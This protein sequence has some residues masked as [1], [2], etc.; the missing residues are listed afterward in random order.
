VL[1]EDLKDFL[2][3]FILEISTDHECGSFFADG[4]FAVDSESMTDYDHELVDY[5]LGYVDLVWEVHFVML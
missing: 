1:D 2:C 4:V 3:V 5:Y